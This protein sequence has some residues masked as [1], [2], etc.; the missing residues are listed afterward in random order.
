[1]S[2]TISRTNVSLTSVLN[3]L[4]ERYESRRAALIEAR[5]HKAKYRTT[6]AELNALSNRDLLDI[7]IS[8]ADIPR[9]AREELRKDRAHENA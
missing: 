6:L 2:I 5:A 1:M 4:R 9:I 7:G 8:R 3:D